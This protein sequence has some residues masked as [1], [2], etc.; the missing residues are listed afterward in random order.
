MLINIK[1]YT[2]EDKFDRRWACYYQRTGVSN[3]RKTENRRLF[4]KR[5]KRELM[6]VEVE[7]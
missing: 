7:E 4:R 1:K 3:S 2:F 6:K 5:L